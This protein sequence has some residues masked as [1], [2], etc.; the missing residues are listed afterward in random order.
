MKQSRKNLLIFIVNLILVTIF[1]LFYNIRKFKYLNIANCFS[2]FLILL[3]SF[4]P[5]LIYVLYFKI[6]KEHRKNILKKMVYYGKFIVKT[7][8]VFLPLIFYLVSLNYLFSDAFESRTTDVNNYLELDETYK[9]DGFLKL[10]P[11]KELVSN[12]K[13]VKYNYVYKT[14]DGNITN[15]DIDL[16]LEI[17]LPHDKYILEKERIKSIDFNDYNFQNSK[18]IYNAYFRNSSLELIDGSTNGVFVSPEEYHNYYY[19]FIAFFDDDNRIIFN[20]SDGYILPFFI[21][22]NR[23]KLYFK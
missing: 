9:I 22:Y 16:Y 1:V 19:R 14:F 12:S 23:D 7:L 13:I 18:I 5:S 3:F 20:Y 21:D 8:A 17:Q 11:S 15:S 4:L 6:A 2:L 10:F